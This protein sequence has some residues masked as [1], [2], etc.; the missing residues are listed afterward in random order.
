MLNHGIGSKISYMEQ[1]YSHHHVQ[2]AHHTGIVI[3]TI[4]GSCAVTFLAALA[5]ISTSP[6]AV[7]HPFN[8]TSQITIKDDTKN[9]TQ[10]GATGQSLF[11]D[12]RGSQRSAGPAG[13]PAQD[14]TR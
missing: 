8:L 7:L 1:A 9:G 3:G 10:L 5:L 11:S 4:I 14:F 12:F 2:Q 13:A 6:K